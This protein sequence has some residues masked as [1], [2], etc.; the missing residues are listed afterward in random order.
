MTAQDSE[1]VSLEALQAGERLGQETFGVTIEVEI[2][3]RSPISNAAQYDPYSDRVR[4]F[5]NGVTTSVKAGADAFELVRQAVAHEFGHACEARAFASHEV[6]PWRCGTYGNC[7]LKT[8]IGS[9]QAKDFLSGFGHLTNVMQDFAIDRRLSEKGI[10]DQTARVRISEMRQIMQKKP[11]DAIGRVKLRLE[12]LFHLPSDVRNHM[13]GDISEQDRELIVQ[14]V[15]WVLGAIEW[16]KT[17]GLVSSREFGDILG[18]E[19][20]TTSYFREFL[21]LRVV[22]ERVPRE[23]LGDLPAFWSSHEYR[24]LHIY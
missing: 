21:G 10:R 24:T 1:P 16:E 13:F 20:V 23:V 3:Q 8:E 2:D 12:T 22:F 7:I 5:A 15:T 18:Y 9:L 6:F 14:F 11:A 4:I 17:V 19:R